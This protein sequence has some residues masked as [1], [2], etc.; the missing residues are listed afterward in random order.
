MSRGPIPIVVQNK[1][2]FCQPKQ[3]II[4]IHF[5]LRKTSLLVS[6]S[7]HTFLQCFAD[8][9]TLLVEGKHLTTVQLKKTR[10]FMPIYL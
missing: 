10:I 8:I 4:T 1:L 5:F 7:M 2:H 3:F 6:R 9:D